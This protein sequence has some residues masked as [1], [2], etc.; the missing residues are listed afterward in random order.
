[1]TGYRAALSA[2]KRTLQL[3]L[4]TGFAS[5]AFANAPVEAVGLFKDRAMIRVSGAEH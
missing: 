5:A 1:M 3:T 4:L 2:A